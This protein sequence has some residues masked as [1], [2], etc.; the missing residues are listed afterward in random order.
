MCVPCENKSSNDESL[1]DEEETENEPPPTNETKENPLV[2][3]GSSPD[4]DGSDTVGENE[5]SEK[6]SEKSDEE[7]DDADEDSD[8][9][10]AKRAVDMEKNTIARPGEERR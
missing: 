2:L 4:S 8:E 6:S 7:N 1:K 3:N 9:E 10:E 5:G